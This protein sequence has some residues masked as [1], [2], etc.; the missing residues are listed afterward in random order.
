MEQGASTLKTFCRLKLGGNAPFIICEDADLNVAL[1]SLLAGK[2]RNAG[3]TCVAPNR[4][5]V[6]EKHYNEFLEKLTLRVQNLK[7]GDG[8]EEGVHVGPLIDQKAVEKMEHLVTDAINKGAHLVCGGE[9]PLQDSNFYQPTILSNVPQD[10]LCEQGEIFG[11]IF[12]LSSFTDDNECLTRSNASD[13]G[14][15]SYVMTQSLKRADFYTRGLEYGM[16]G[17]NTGVISF[18]A[19]PFGGYKDSGLNREG[20]Q[21]GLAAYQ[22]TKYIAVQT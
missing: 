18:A 10:A 12:A 5:F 2:I 8:R 15:A 4:I 6:A 13:V 14:L 1:D 3:Q 11:P 9:T 17:V 22:Q 20:G 21:E 7:M 16:V 19:A